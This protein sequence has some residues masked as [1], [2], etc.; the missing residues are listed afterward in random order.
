[1][2]FGEHEHDVVKQRYFHV[3]RKLIG[4]REREIEKVPTQ[5]RRERASDY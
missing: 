5:E 1:M 4:Q 3:H 2:E